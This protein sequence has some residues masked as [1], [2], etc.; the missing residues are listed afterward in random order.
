MTASQAVTKKMAW[1]TRVV[2]DR[3]FIAIP[4]ATVTIRQPA[5]ATSRPARIHTVVRQSPSGGNRTRV[6]RRACS[7]AAGR[8]DGGYEPLETAE[9]IEGLATLREAGQAML[10]R[11]LWIGAS[12]LEGEHHHRSGEIVSLLDGNASGKSTTMK[13]LLGLMTPNVAA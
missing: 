10:R 7:V 12:T 2:P 11:V 8:T 3:Q 9:L 6:E 5:P 13:V 1:T 4:H